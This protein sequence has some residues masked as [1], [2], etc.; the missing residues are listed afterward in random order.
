MR[1]G[2]PGGSVRLAHH[3]ACIMTSAQRRALVSTR[4]HAV[5]R[6]PVCIRGPAAAT[7]SPQ[8]RVRTRQAGRGTRGGCIPAQGCRLGNSAAIPAIDS[9]IHHGLVLLL[10]RSV[11][12]KC[13]GGEW[14]GGCLRR[15]STLLVTGRSKETQGHVEP[16]MP[17]LAS[18]LGPPLPARCMQPGVNEPEKTVQTAT[19][20]I[21]HLHEL[22]GNMGSVHW[23][24][25][26][27]CPYT[28]WSFQ[29]VFLG[30]ICLPVAPAMSPSPRGKAATR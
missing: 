16:R 26:S 29:W 4:L 13:L 1:G 11:L 30:G 15:C 10:I 2:R 3:S 8:P 18:D 7:D 25:L 14:T 6:K 22:C 27:A 17:G 28:P 21:A 12:G 5:F 9:L 20:I 24:R 19:A 23:Q